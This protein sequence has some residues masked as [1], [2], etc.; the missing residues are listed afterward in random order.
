MAQLI[1]AWCKKVIK[2]K[3]KTATGQDSH[4][5]CEDCEKKLIEEIKAM[6]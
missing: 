5:I 2:D 6:K 1:C 3:I 4:G